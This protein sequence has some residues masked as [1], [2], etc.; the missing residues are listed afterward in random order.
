MA[1]AGFNESLDSADDRMKL[2]SDIDLEL[3]PD[4]LINAS[5][6]S[7][8]FYDNICKTSYVKSNCAKMIGTM[9]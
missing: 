9:H 8:K 1:D 7:K 4:D 6:L 2:I 5:D 3:I